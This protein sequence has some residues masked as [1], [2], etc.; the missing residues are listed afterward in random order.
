MKMKNLI[1]ALTAFFTMIMWTGCSQETQSETEQAAEEVLDATDA[2]AEDAAD[3][4]DDVAEDVED[5]V[6]EGMN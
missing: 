3:A 4:V 1:L 6:E 5:E 2:A